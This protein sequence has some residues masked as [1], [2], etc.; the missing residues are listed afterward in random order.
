MIFS[1]NNEQWQFVEP[2]IERC[3]VNWND[4]LMAVKVRFSH[5]AVGVAHK[6]SLHTQLSYVLAGRF[7]VQL[8]DR[9]CVLETGDSFLA[10]KECIHGVIA[11]AEGSVLL[12]V[13]TPVRSDF[14]A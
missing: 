12:D 4:E 1:Q 10:A 5:L 9:T 13:F 7:E 8:G 14:L 6:H 3:I 2:G 11:L